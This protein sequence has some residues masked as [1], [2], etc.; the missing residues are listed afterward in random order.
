MVSGKATG[1]S[2]RIRGESVSALSRLGGVRIIPANTGRILVVP[3]LGGVSRDHPREYGENR[4][5]RSTRTAIPGSSPRIRGESAHSATGT[6][7]IRIIP[8]NTGRIKPAGITTPQLRDHPREY[9]ENRSAASPR[10]L[11]AGSSPRI[12]GESRLPIDDAVPRRI[13]P[14]NTGRMY[15]DVDDEAE[16]GDHPREYGENAI[17]LNN[18]AIRVGSSPRIRGECTTMWTMKR[19]PGIIPANTGRITLRY[20]LAR[21][22]WDHPR[23]Y[24]ENASTMYTTCYVSGSS[25]RIRGES[26]QNLI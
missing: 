10:F 24:G 17:D 26:H 23:E 5:R 19:N 3:V 11:L 4:I 2:P 13:I 14:A 21:R 6:R 20:H 8:A 15:D 25:P 1:S 9:G 22:T 12:R 18:A 16:S 7:R